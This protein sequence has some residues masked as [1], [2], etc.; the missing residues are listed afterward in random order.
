M[1][2]EIIHGFYASALQLG[3]TEKDEDG[4]NIRH[5]GEEQERA[6]LHGTQHVRC[7]G[8]DTVVDN[9]VCE[10]AAGHADRS[11]SCGE[12]LS[13]YNV[14]CYRVPERPAEGVE[15]NPGLVLDRNLFECVRFKKL[16]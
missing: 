1:S 10:E 4:P 14:W 13:G 5:D 12:D 11:N 2:K 16:T 9:P 15:I 6:V 7:G 3:Q 8:G